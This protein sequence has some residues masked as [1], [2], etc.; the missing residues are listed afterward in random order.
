MGTDPG[1]CHIV[2]PKG[3]PGVSRVHARIWVS[4]GEIVVMDMGST[5]GTTIDGKR[6]AQG[7]AYRLRPGSLLCLGGVE[8]FQAI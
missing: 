3:T 6:L 4:R 7:C 8:T 1:K 2:F 5:Y